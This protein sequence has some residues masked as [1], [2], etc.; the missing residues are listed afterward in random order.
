MFK[1]IFPP[2]KVFV[3]SSNPFLGFFLKFF[4]SVYL[5]LIVVFAGVWMASSGYVFT[6]FLGKFYTYPYQNVVIFPLE[7]L[8]NAMDHW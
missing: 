5:I 6:R 4:W 2:K 7:S 1:I 8:L 3:C